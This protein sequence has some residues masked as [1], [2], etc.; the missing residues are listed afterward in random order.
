MRYIYAEVY[1]TKTYRILEVQPDRLLPVIIAIH[2]GSFY[3]GSA[4]NFGPDFLL[5]ED[6]VVL[7]RF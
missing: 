4:N 6:D 3:E 2:G 5:N 1:E 7:V